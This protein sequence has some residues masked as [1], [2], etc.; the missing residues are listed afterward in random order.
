MYHVNYFYYYNNNKNNNM[1][2]LLSRKEFM[3]LLKHVLT[4]IGI[5]K[6]VSET[7]DR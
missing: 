6:A 1:I 7:R 3:F 2:P 5:F 4:N